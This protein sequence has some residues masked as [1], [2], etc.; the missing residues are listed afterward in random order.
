[1]ALAAC[2]MVMSSARAMAGKAALNSVTYSGVA[3]SRSASNAQVRVK[4]PGSEESA[5]V[6]TGF[7]PRRPAISR[8]EVTG[9]I[10]WAAST[11]SRPRGSCCSAGVTKPLGQR[12]LPSTSTRPSRNCAENSRA[13]RK[14]SAW[15]LRGSRPSTGAA[16][17]VWRSGPMPTAP[18]PSGNATP[19]A[20]AWR[21]WWQVAQAMLRLPLRILSKNSSWPRRS[22][23]AVK[24][25][26]RRKSRSSTGAIAAAGSSAAAVPPATSMTA[27][28]N[29]RSLAMPTSPPAHRA[30][31]VEHS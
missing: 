11:D 18:S 13:P 20:V 17:V 2:T 5:A 27:S 22:S 15:L 26:L 6:A 8:L 23:A 4:L 28:P 14:K 16:S 1:M 9:N 21:G 12:P 7:S 10:A 31:Q 3:R 24:T 25:P 19:S 30:R 29:P